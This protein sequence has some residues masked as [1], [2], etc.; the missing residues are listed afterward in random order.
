MERKGPR[1]R[2]VN[3]RAVPSRDKGELGGNKKDGPAQEI[4]GVALGDRMVFS[5]QAEVWT[6]RGLLQGGGFARENVGEL[7]FILIPGTQEPATAVV[8]FVSPSA[9]YTLAASEDVLWPQI[10]GMVMQ[11]G[12]DMDGFYASVSFGGRYAY[13]ED[14]RAK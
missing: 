9:P 12:Y 8:G 11:L 5:E 13:F 7:S 1:N 6:L 2:S 3:L 14:F 4:V 10:R